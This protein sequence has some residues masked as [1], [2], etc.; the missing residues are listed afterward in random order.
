MDKSWYI[1]GPVILAILTY[2]FIVVRKAEEGKKKDTALGCLAM[3]GLVG[4]LPLMFLYKC[5]S[6]IKWDG[7]R[8]EESWGTGGVKVIEKFTYL[9]EEK[10]G[11]YKSYYKDSG[12]R[13]ETGSYDRGKKIG[14]WIAWHENGQK[15]SETDYSKYSPHRLVTDWDENGRIVSKDYYK[16]TRG[17][18]DEWV[19]SK[20]EG[21]HENGQKAYEGN[22]DEYTDGTAKQWHQNGQLF[23]KETWNNGKL[24]EIEIYDQQGKPCRFTTYKSGSGYVADY[25]LW[26]FAE[27]PDKITIYENYKAIRVMDDY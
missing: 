1:W 11:P 12:R 20:T 19:E 26:N 4:G 21:W 15:E 18:D 14:L 9:D 2:L 16:K 24:L 27:G 3:L 10:H 8:T 7:E 23:K 13:R 25:D 17:G 5:T 22:A 6:T